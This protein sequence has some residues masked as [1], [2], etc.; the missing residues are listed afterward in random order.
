MRGETSLAHAY[1]EQR[2]KIGYGRPEATSSHPANIIRQ[3]LD[4]L[5]WLT[6]R[7]WPSIDIFLPKTLTPY[8]EFSRLLFELR[9]WNEVCRSPSPNAAVSV[10]VACG[11]R[12]PPNSD[13]AA[14]SQLASASHNRIGSC[15]IL[16][17]VRLWISLLACSLSPQSLHPISLACRSS[18]AA[19]RRLAHA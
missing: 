19:C 7:Q 5:A 2:M 12:C 4:A 13:S 8:A 16:M 9:P 17:L 14:V 18:A 11:L 1:V 15:L 6:A 10:C 3:S